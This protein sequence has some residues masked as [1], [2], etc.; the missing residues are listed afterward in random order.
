M[1]YLVTYGNLSQVK[2][3]RTV[4]RLDQISATSAAPDVPVTCLAID[5]YRWRQPLCLTFAHPFSTKSTAS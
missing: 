5:P 2:M 3:S 1:Y 4:L